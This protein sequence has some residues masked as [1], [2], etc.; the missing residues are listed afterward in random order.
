MACNEGTFRGL[1][2]GHDFSVWLKNRT[3][4]FISGLPI[5]R[6]GLAPQLLFAGSDQ[7]LGW[8]CL[9]RGAL[10]GSIGITGSRKTYGWLG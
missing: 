6:E 5:A 9:L 7:S 1:S 2:G 8:D 4:L 10:M 3:G